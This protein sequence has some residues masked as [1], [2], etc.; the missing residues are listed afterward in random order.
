MKDYLCK[1]EKL[2]GE[3]EKI[4][5]TIMKLQFEKVN[6]NVACA[7][8]LCNKD[9]LYKVITDVEDKQTYKA[10]VDCLRRLDE[11]KSE[12]D[13]LQFKKRVKLREIDG[14]TI[15]V[16]KDY[17]NQHSV[18]FYRPMDEIDICD[19]INKDGFIKGVKI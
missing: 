14:L 4:D 7:P 17:I 16:R 3:I 10:L 19:L 18:D 1:I 5:D 13:I 12:L 2:R 11:I 15:A 8:I 9:S 6:I